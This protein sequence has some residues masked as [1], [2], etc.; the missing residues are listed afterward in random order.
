MFTVCTG[1][2][3]TRLSNELGAGRAWRGA[4]IVAATAVLG[5]L[6][7]G[8]VGIVYS[9]FRGELG[10]VFT[11]DSSVQSTV[12]SLVPIMAI[13]IVGDGWICVCGGAPASVQIPVTSFVLSRRLICVSK[14][15]LPGHYGCTIMCGCVRR[16]SCKELWERTSIYDLTQIE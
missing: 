1:A 16:C 14:C 10:P 8:G 12:T 15:W 7:G 3:S 2:A 11:I 6:I 4:H 9:A 13:M 5:T